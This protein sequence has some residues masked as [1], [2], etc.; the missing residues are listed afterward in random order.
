[1]IKLLKRKRCKQCGWELKL[2]SRQNFCSEQCVSIWDKDKREHEEYEKRK[3][4]R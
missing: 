2:F 1:M 4:S 3:S